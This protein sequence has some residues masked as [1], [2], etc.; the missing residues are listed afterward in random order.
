MF[1]V[2]SRTLRD[3]VLGHIDAGN[4]CMGGETL[5]TRDEEETL[6]EHVETLAE[7][8]Y[9]Y[10]NV[11][12]QQLAGEL[13]FDLGKKK[14]NKA[15][16]NN[17][18]AGFLRRWNDRLSS[19]N[20][21]KLESTRAKC[22]TPEVLD[23]YFENLKQVLTENDLLD[24]PQFIYNLDETG[25]QPEHRPPNIVANPRT[26]PQAITSPR[27]TT[28]T[29]IACENALR[30]SLPPYF[31]FKGKRWNPDLMKGATAG[32]KGVL[33]E[34]GWSNGEIFQDYLKT[35]FI[36]YVRPTQASSQPI[37]LIYDGHSSHKTPQLI[38]WAKEQGLIL[39]VLPAHSSHLLQPLDVSIF[40]PFKNYYYSECS[41][42][43]HQHLGQT[44]TKY[45]ICSIACRAYL[46]AMTPLNI[47]AG[48]R[49]TGI[50]PLRKEV[51]SPEKLIP[52]ESF[53]E[54]KPIEKV[55]AMKAGKDA[56]GEFLRIK[57]ERQQ[58]EMCSTCICGKKK[59]QKPNA[60]GT[61]ITGDKYMEELEE[62]EKNKTINKAK[63]TQKT[64]PL[65][66]PKPSTSGNNIN[67]TKP[68]T[69]DSDTDFDDEETNESDVCCV[70]KKSSP[71]AI[72]E[73][74][75]LK[76]VNWA[77]CD[78]CMHWVH[79]AFCTSTRVVRRHSTFLCPHCTQ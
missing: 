38:S 58:R 50:Y 65:D 9:G 29:L 11:R 60:A 24:K 18:L 48:F 4:Y 6:V 15:M 37:L 5:F 3:R 69:V 17:W 47:Q 71:P 36:P 23:K 54:D 68:V 8:G 32:A 20:P 41:T 28:T 1:G 39:F 25:L 51:I 33:S 10:T 72:H 22:A 73:L 55:K 26:K 61:A 13:A 45:E 30:N 66:S 12:L 42:Y 63:A 79:L 40:G 67:R 62:Y 14:I 2:P 46:K 56:V 44:I 76:I 49:K 53:R 16:S 43:M 34:S 64:M 75:A 78:N 31:V 19:V 77:Q 27:S 52:C 7:L 74:P 70:C 35:H 57:E 59:V 21:R